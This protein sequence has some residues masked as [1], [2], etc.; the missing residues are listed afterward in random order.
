MLQQQPVQAELAFET[1][2]G[3]VFWCE[4]QVTPVADATDLVAGRRALS[5]SAGPPGP[6]PP[7]PSRPDLDGGDPASDQPNRRPDAV[8]V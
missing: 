5:T 8:K 7:S 2:R 3:R 1:R 4:I 6:Q